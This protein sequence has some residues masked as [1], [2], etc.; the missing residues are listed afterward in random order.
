MW[1][2]DL[3]NRLA[4]YTERHPDHTLTIC[5]VFAALANG[6]AVTDSFMLATGMD[7]ETEISSVTFSALAKLNFSDTVAMTTVANYIEDTA[8]KHAAGNVTSIVTLDPAT[9]GITNKTWV[10]NN[11]TVTSTCSSTVNPAV[12]R[13]SLAIGLVCIVVYAFAGYLVKFIRRKPLISKLIPNLI[14]QF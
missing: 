5:D 1:L 9:V 7:N 10:L 6:T 2:P 14:T 3:Y 11:S 4:L 8:T 12:F 13:N